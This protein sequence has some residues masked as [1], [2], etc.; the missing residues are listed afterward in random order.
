MYIVHSYRPHIP[1]TSHHS[2]VAVAFH[3]RAPESSNDE[4]PDYCINN[5][6]NSAESRRSPSR[7]LF[8]FD[9]VGSNWNRYH[10]VAASVRS[11]SRVCVHGFRRGCQHSFS[12][13]PLKRL[14]RPH[15]RY[16]IPRCSRTTVGRAEH[17]RRPIVIVADSRFS[18]ARRGNEN[19]IAAATRSITFIR[20]IY[21]SSAFVSLL[22]RMTV[23]VFYKRYVHLRFYEQIYFTIF[24]E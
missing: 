24:C 14:K 6:T 21:T 2:G 11:R 7:A 4:A 19:R 15:D 9:S 17:D 5:A 16:V 8:G 22:Y 18:L 13:V 10:I 23:F 20:Y 12:A 1:A 3:P